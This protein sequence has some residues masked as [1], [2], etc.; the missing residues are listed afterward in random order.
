MR[1]AVET[2]GLKKVFGRGEKTVLAV[3]GLDLCVDPGTVYGLLGR[4]GAG[5]TTTLRLLAGAL[6]PTAGTARALGTDM[7][8]AGARD[9][10]RF[11]YITQEQQLDRSL[12]GS[13]ILAYLSRFYPLWDGARAEQ[14]ARRFEIPMDRRVGELS[15][16]QQRLMSCILALSGRPELLLLDE[17]AAGLDPVA[18]R[19]L[20]DVLV[21]LLAEGTRPTI[22]LSTHI[23]SDVER[24]ADRVGMMSDGTLHLEA[25]LDELQQNCRHVQIVFDSGAVPADF[26]PEGV[27]RES[28]EAQVW[29]GIVK[30]GNGGLAALEATQGATVRCFPMGL[31][32]LFVELFSREEAA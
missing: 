3:N 8:T 5:K 20:I 12:T 10:S 24:L 18:R 26:A 1:A 28:R 16:G 4:N 14:I 6:A 17:P 19:E 31:E 15:G 13:Q 23:V 27:L 9:R 25:G 2:A 32:D 7:R 29:T 21:E 22:L 30:A 11:A